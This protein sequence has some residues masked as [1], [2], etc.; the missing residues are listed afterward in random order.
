M[1]TV[2][3]QYSFPVN[4]LMNDQVD[5]KVEGVPKREIHPL[6]NVLATVAAVISTKGRASVQ[7]VNLS[8]QVRY[9]NNH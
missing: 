4:E 7:H 8:I 1:D 5:L 9:T 6:M 3:A 2:F